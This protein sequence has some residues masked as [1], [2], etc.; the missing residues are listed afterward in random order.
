MLGSKHT[1]LIE[2]N[3]N[4]NGVLS[5]TNKLTFGVPQGSVL[6][7]TLYC[8]HTKPVSDIIRPLVNSEIR[9]LGVTFDQTMSMQSHVYYI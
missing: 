8:L 3:V 2:F 6:G 5:D 9:N 7:L 1:C 4:I